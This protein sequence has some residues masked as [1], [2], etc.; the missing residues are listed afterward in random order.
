M[1]H[2]KSNVRDL[3]FNLFEVLGVDAAF[4]T[5]EF[6]ELDA[7]T[8]RE[9]LSEM[10]R[11]AEGPLAES[12]ADGDR[13]PPIFDPETHSVTLPEAF[14]KSYRAIIDG[15]WDKAR[16]RRGT[17]RLPMPR[18]LCWALPSSSSARTPR[19][20][21]TPAAPLRRASSTT[22]APPSSAVGRADRR[23]AAGAPRWC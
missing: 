10:S 16:H 21:C 7:D 23:D 5:G 20:S 6:G 13:N 12:F 11:L 8:A 14:K 19:C 9:M 3:E 18:A 1:S 2:Y 4:G 15:G 17:R 22:A